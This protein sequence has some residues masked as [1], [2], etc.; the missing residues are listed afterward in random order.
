MGG[1]VGGGRGEGDA[2]CSARGRRDGRL[3][4][5]AAAGM[6][7]SGRDTAGRPDRHAYEWDRRQRECQRSVCLLSAHP[8]GCASLAQC[9]TGWVVRNDPDV[10]A[11]VTARH[12]LEYVINGRRVTGLV[13]ATFPDGRTVDLAG[14]CVLSA[15]EPGTG[16]DPSPEMD[17][18]VVRLAAGQ[19]YPAPPVPCALASGDADGSEAADERGSAL[20]GASCTLLHHP[21]GHKSVVVT[22]RGTVF[23]VVEGGGQPWC[24]THNLE[25]DGGSSGG[26]LIDAQ[27]RAF[28]IH[29]A[30]E[31]ADVKHAM[32]LSALHVGLGEESPWLGAPPVEHGRD[33]VYGLPPRCGNFVGRVDALAALSRAVK[34]DGLWWWC[35]RVSQALA[36][37]R[38]WV[39]GLAR[40]A[41]RASTVPSYGCEQTRLRPCATTW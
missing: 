22:P 2:G 34:D 39:S 38:W 4:I 14:A 17:T 28:A 12:V 29:C 11:M 5:I 25:S 6:A 15:P 31:A 36:S 3:S 23:T 24:V 7:S 19:Q 27:G 26:M 9:G 16:A 32:L 18:V 20:E 33:V 10:A 1:V 40:P 41:S 35:R 13:S 21:R 37:P 8:A 30:R